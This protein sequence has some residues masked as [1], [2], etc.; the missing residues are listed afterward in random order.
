MGPL[1]ARAT[2][3]R[4]QTGRKGAS[5]GVSVAASVE[6]GTHRLPPVDLSAVAH[7]DDRHDQFRIYELVQ[8][9]TVALTDTVLVVAAGGP[10]ASRE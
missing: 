6:A 8:N 3:S 7:A 2:V 9:A 1:E 5:I 4:Q 10:D